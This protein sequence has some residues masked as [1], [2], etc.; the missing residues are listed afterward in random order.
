M[1]P[2][3]VKHLYG[4]ARKN[5]FYWLLS[6]YLVGVGILT[7]IFTA[8]PLLTAFFGG[9]N[10]FSML[11]VFTLGRNMFWVSG[12]ILIF[13]AGILVPITI[14]GAIA[15]ERDSRTL[16]LLLVTTLR[17]T[18]IVAGKMLSACTTGVIYLFAPLPLVL[19]SFW[20]GGVSATQLFV[21]I[22]VVLV[23]ML[24]SCSLALYF[25]AIVRRT[26]NAVLL[27]YILNTAVLPVMLVITLILGNTYDVM[28]RYQRFS[29][30][31]SLFVA[32]LLQFGWVILCGLHPLSA[33]VASEILGVEQRSWFILRFDVNHY[34]PL[35]DTMSLLGV[36]HLPSPW[37]VYV[38][39]AL[40]ASGFFL[41]QT[42][43]QLGKPDD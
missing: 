16:D 32:T 43:K 24:F 18:N 19:T 17:P 21:L 42:V 34:N 36:A 5:R 38:I 29:A 23:V 33:A 25:S 20:I 1:N 13:A 28:N 11:E 41:W 14:L 22:V 35:T 2:L 30:T 31:Q 37:I 6:A 9:S 12:L 7:A 39:L 40:A 8:T 4:S 3:I 15:G 27:Y 26:L 10:T